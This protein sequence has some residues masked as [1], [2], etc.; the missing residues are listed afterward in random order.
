[1]ALNQRVETYDPQGNIED[2]AYLAAMISHSRGFSQEQFE[3]L[4]PMIH[5]GKITDDVTLMKFINSRERVA[6]RDKLTRT[7]PGQGQTR[8]S[9]RSTPAGA[10][11]EQKTGTL[12]TRGTGMF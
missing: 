10:G 4:I 2:A 9:N 1:M 5:S 8:I 3:S 6:Q 7:K 12:L 11:G